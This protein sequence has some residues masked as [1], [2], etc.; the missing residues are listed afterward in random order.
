VISV[1]LPW[2]RATGSA[3]VAEIPGFMQAQSS[4][5]S[6]SVS[7]TNCAWGWLT[8]AVALTGLAATF[9]RPRQYLQEKTKLTMAA[10]GGLIALLAIIGMFTAGA[11]LGGSVQFGNE[12]ASA[13]RSAGTAFGVY[14]TLLCGFIS[15]GL[16]FVNE[17]N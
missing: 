16:G 10:I 2:A 11:E 8:L 5:M 12:F 9:M 3:S 1:F 6:V 7:G 15:G 4:S 14:V 13:S 17:W